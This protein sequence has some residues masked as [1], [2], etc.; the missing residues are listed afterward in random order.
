MRWIIAQ[1][2]PGEV[3]HVPWSL[4]DTQVQGVF[5][6]LLGKSFAQSIADGLNQ[7]ETQ[8]SAR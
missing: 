2:E 4:I 5:G 7:A 1:D 3:E 8:E 6:H